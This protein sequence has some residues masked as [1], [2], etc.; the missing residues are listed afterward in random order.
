LPTITAQA[1]VVPDI[2][3]KTVNAQLAQALGEL[4]RI[5]CRPVM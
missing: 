3:A 1:D 5:S 4:P 2:E